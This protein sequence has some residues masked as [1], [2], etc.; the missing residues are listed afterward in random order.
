MRDGLLV[1]AIIAWKMIRDCCIS[2]IPT[3]SQEP[4]VHPYRRWICCWSG[5]SRTS[6]RVSVRIATKTNNRISNGYV[7]N[8]FESLFTIK[9]RKERKW[10]KGWGFHVSFSIL[11]T[12]QRQ[13]LVFFW[14]VYQM[15]SWP[16]GERELVPPNPRGTIDD[17]SYLTAYLDLWNASKILYLGVTFHTIIWYSIS[18]QVGEGCTPHKK[19]RGW[20]Y[21]VCS[22]AQTQSCLIP[23]DWLLHFP[24]TLIL[25][26]SF[27][28]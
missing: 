10:T 13:D 15:T 3:C 21:Q 1:F 18:L 22:V 6:S 27:N 24:Q 14:K 7:S 11:Q 28:R 4:L 9:V 26:R 5:S 25:D 20:G 19:K 2:V 12:V 17:I 8:N 23:E 16:D